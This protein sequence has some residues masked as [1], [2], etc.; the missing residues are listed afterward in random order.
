MQYLSNLNI[1]Q[2]WFL[3]LLLPQQ[4]QWKKIVLHVHF[5]ILFCNQYLWNDYAFDSG[6]Q[7][8]GQP[9]LLEKNNKESQLCSPLS[10]GFHFLAFQNQN[11]QKIPKPNDQQ[12][13]LCSLCSLFYLIYLG[14]GTGRFS[15]FL[16]AGN[17]ALCS[18]NEYWNKFLDESNRAML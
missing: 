5:F 17:S 8:L 11:K 15:S 2:L 3:W 4:D 6:R 1:F 7:G 16:R 18:A 14:P 10:Y 9:A 13:C 12:P